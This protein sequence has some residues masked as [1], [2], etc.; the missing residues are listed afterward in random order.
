MTQLAV[1][2]AEPTHVGYL[3]RVVAKLARD[4]GFSE[5]AAGKVAI[6]VN[7]LAGN[8]VKHATQGQVLIRSLHREETWGIEIMALDK[9]PGMA[10]ITKC[11]QDGYS[12]TGSPGTGLG[13]VARLSALFDIYSTP[14]AG[15]AVLAQ[16]W[17]MPWSGKDNRHHMEIGAVCLPH[18]QEEVCGDVWE[19]LESPGRSLIFLADGLGHGQEASDA[20]REARRIFLENPLLA[21][22]DLILKA[23][24]ALHATRGAAVAIAV[25]AHADSV[26]HYCGVGNISAAIMSQQRRRGMISHSGIV[27][28]E[29]RKIQEF[30]YPF[31]KD[32]L[33]VM[34]S[35]G[36]ASRWGLESYPGIQSR[37]LGLIAGVLYRDY[38]RG[39]DDVTV[40][41]ARPRNKY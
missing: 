28:H 30:T 12:T 32:A 13:A 31:V 5:A 2:V 39:S 17:S 37:H 11:L 9:G 6:V 38:G 16:L 21:P 23:H 20:A 33:L 26:V 40:V 3:R 4:L 27:G 14:G 25:L 15:T 24:S 22:A 41:V 34:H 36:L 19:H 18:P 29:V 1:P 7:E 8:L 10:E 35:D